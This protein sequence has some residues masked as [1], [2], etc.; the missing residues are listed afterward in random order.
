MVGQSRRLPWLLLAPALAVLTLVLAVPLGYC[1]YLSLFESSLRTGATQ[2]TGLGNYLRLAADQR[3]L[4]SA[5][6]TLGFVAAS[7]GLELGLGLGLALLMQ[8]LSRGRGLFRA[9]VM[10]P[11]AIPTVVS[12]LLWAWIFNDRLGLANAVISRAGL[13]PVAWL[14]GPGTAWAALLTAE[15]WKTAPF[16]ALILLAGLQMI[17]RELYEAAEIDGAG[18]WSKF[19]G[20]TLP[21]LAPVIMLAMLFRTVDA[22]RVFDLVAVMTGG[23]PAG[24]TEVLS[25]YNYKVLFTNLEFGYGSAVS[26]ALFLLAM[27]GSLAYLKAMLGRERVA[28]G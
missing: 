19:S 20:I 17:P 1:F 7:L 3:F 8:H 22:M 9:A 13:N 12:G 23:G 24:S 25:L 15:V 10:L 11:W 28:G 4:G 16:V 2:F 14:A 6:R 18:P 21:L 5:L 27:A 26:T